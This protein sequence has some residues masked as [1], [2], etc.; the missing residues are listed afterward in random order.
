MYLSGSDIHIFPSTITRTHDSNARL[1]TEENLRKLLATSGAPDSYV[2]SSS[3]SG[4][5][6]LEFVLHGYYVRAKNISIVTSASD[7]YAHI[8]LDTT[9]DGNYRLWGSESERQFTAVT[10]NDSIECTPPES[11]SGNY[12]HH[13]LK[14][15]VKEQDSWVIP[16][17]SRYILDGGVID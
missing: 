15:L 12:E 17:E 7:I 10:F 5:A 4:G 14:I 1:L 3:Y 11:I 8:F 16:I 9:S 6:A 2:L 13:Y